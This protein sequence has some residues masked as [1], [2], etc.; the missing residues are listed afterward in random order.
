MFQDRQGRPIADEFGHQA[1][2]GR[3]VENVVIG[4]FLAV[5]L[6]EIVMEPAVERGSLMRVFPVSQ[7]LGQG[8]LHQQWIGQCQF[9]GFRGPW[10]RTRFRGTHRS[11]GPGEVFGNPGIVSGGAG[12]NARGQPPPQFQGGSSRPF[13]LG[14]HLRIVRRIDHDRDAFVVFRRAPQHGRSADVYVFNRLIEGHAGPG[15]RFF[16]R[17]EV[18]HDEVDGLDLVL[19]HG[20]FVRWISPPVEQA[21]MHLGMKSLHPAIEHFRKLR[22]DAQVGDFQP[23]FS[24][25]FGGASGR[26]QF[27]A[28]LGQGFGKRNKP[29]L[30]KNG[31]QRARNLQ[32]RPAKIL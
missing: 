1:R 29:A 20:R 5:E 11:K 2:R 30:V 17:V 16:K 18:H 23:S 28:S 13:D 31:N 15:D 7:R 10:S 26:N 25:G 6:L 8:R 32:H 4:K 12:V 19:P 24:Q 27:N 3:Q 21:A 22:P 14:G 9:L